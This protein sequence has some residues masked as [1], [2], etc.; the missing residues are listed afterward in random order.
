MKRPNIITIGNDGKAVLLGKDGI[1]Y[2]Y[3]IDFMK[4]EM[5]E[6]HKVTINEVKMEISN[7]Q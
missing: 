2:E 4:K 1:Y 6:M 7:G 5:K 3:G